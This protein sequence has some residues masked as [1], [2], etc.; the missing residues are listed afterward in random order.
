MARA[1]KRRGED[2]PLPPRPPEGGPDDQEYVYMSP[3][4]QKRKPPQYSF[5]MMTPDTKRFRVGGERMRDQ[6]NFEDMERIREQQRQPTRLKK[7][8]SVKKKYADGGTVQKAIA[9]QPSMMGPAVG[10]AIKAEPRM[11]AAPSPAPKPTPSP[12]PK[13]G[14]SSVNPAIAKGVSMLNN[15]LAGRPGSFFKKGGSIKKAMGRKR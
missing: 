9:N 7:G 2:T 4:E 8:G 13:G 5:P 11:A 6:R 10:R 14:S 15:R 12:K 3:E 1:P